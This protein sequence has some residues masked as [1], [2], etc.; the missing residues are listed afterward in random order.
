MSNTSRKITNCIQ[1]YL[2]LVIRK[3]KLFVYIELL[4]LPCSINQIEF[5]FLLPKLVPCDKNS[6]VNFLLNSEN[7]ILYVSDLGEDGTLGVTL[8]SCKFFVY[9]QL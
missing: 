6:L 4:I 1:I 5:F 2:E 9:T 7:K 8:T 3:L